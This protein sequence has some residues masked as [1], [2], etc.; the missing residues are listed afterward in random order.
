[1][2]RN[3]KLAKSIS[4]AEWGMFQQMLAY[5]C[6]K[7]GDTLVKIQPAYTHKTAQSVNI[8]SRSH[9]LSAPIFAQNAGQY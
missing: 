4:D 9:S 8:V 3:R 6:K 2:I 1:M 5:K 7:N